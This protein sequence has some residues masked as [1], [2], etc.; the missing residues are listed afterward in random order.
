MPDASFFIALFCLILAVALIVFSAFHFFIR[1]SF[2]RQHFSSPQ[3]YDKLYSDFSFS[4]EEAEFNSGKEKLKGRFYGDENAKRLIVF[5]HGLGCGHEAYLFF[6]SE[7]IKRGYRIFAYDANGCGE[8]DGKTSYGL[9]Q[10]SIALKDAL[11]FLKAEGIFDKYEVFAMGHSWGGFAA[12][13]VPLF[14]YPVK[15][16]VSI[17][18]YSYSVPMLFNFTHIKKY[19]KLL[20]PIFALEEKF[21]FGKYSKINA[22][23]ALKSSTVPALVIHSKNDEVVS[24]DESIY[25]E[26]ENIANP[27]VKYKLVD[28]GGAD[29]HDG[30]LYS[31]RR[32][33]YVEELSFK[34]SLGASAPI[35]K[36]LANEPNEDLIDYIVD[37][38]NSVN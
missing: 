4:V 29:T 34:L 9:I 30:I 11:G 2:L 21:T 6:L 5:S 18:G 36:E 14:D 33:E 7:F 24:L 35:D 22:V 32:S 1:N 10:S 37:F 12:A 8:S 27:L 3:V 13:T 17:S 26:S 38:I 31:A 28:M 16:I 25:S 20:T 19:Q 15:G 23:S